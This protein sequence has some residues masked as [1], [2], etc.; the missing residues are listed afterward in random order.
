[1][2]AP[3]NSGMASRRTLLTGAA[4]AV[5]LSLLAAQGTAHAAGPGRIRRVVLVPRF[6][7]DASADWYHWLLRRLGVRS[8][9]VPLLPDPSAPGIDQTVAA[10]ADAV[11][12]DRAHTLLIGHSVG[13]RALLAYLDR[14]PGDAF[15]GLVSVAGWFTID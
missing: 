15:A 3:M 14:H 4:A 6:G 13:S 11:G 10:I 9:V 2:K 5:P 12:D 1:M 7:G 8:T